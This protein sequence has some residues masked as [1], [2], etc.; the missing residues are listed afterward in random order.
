MP[1][2]WIEKDGLL[3]YKNRLYIPENEALQTEIAQGWHD[4]LVAGHFGQ[5]KTIEIVTRDFY[6]KKV[7]DWIRDYVGSCDECQ[8]SKSPRHAKYGLL[9]PLE[10]PYA[11]WSS[12]ST[13]FIAQLPESQGK[14]Q[15]MVVVDRFTKMPHF[16]GLHENATAKDVADTFLREVWKIQ[17]LPT[18]II[19][20]M[21]VKFSGEF[22]ESLCK[23]LGVKRRMSTAYH[24]QNDGQT[25]R[26][27]QVLEGYLRTFVNY[28]QNDWY[29]LLPLAEHADNN[30]ATNAHKMT[31]FFA[32]YVFHPQTEWMKEREAHNPGATLYAHW[33]Q[34]IHGQAK[35]TLENTRELMKKYYDRKATEQPSIE[36]GDLVMLNAKNIRTKRP[37]KKLSPKL[38]GPFKVLE[39]KGSRAYKLEISPR[40]KIH[41]VF[42]VSLLEPYRASNRPNREQPPRDPEDIE[43][44]LEWEVER[45]VKSEIISYTRKVRGRNKPMKELRYFVKWKGCAEDKNTWEPP[46]GKKNAQEE[47]ERFHRENPEMPGPREVE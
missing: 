29:Q 37:S 38:Y 10:V 23:M 32:N 8:H 18:E 24:P 42:H 19:S 4:S 33:I 2:E 44:D 35:Q 36:V 20:D 21:D 41:P 45:I 7:A 1:D 26:T 16:I 15:I 11:A 31:P 22:W 17:G 43:R 5:E 6:W 12:I 47:V 40:W 46:E 28:D 39:K 13:D 27:N 25:E 9:Q 34:D 3:Y 30:S 14:T